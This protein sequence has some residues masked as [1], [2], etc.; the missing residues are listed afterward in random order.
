MSAATECPD[1]G[2]VLNL[3]ADRPAECLLCGYVDDVVIDEPQRPAL[4]I[5]RRPTPP[6]RRPPPVPWRFPRNYRP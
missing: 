6:V 3:Q 5:A 2:F 1:C 4:R